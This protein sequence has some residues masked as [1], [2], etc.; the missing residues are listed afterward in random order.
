VL[1]EFDAHSRADSAS[2]EARLTSRAPR[3]NR[4]DGSAAGTFGLSQRRPDL[5]E[6]T[7]HAL[8]DQRR[9]FGCLGAS[10]ETESACLKIGG[11]GP[12]SSTC[13]P[14][15]NAVAKSS[16]PSPEFNDLAERNTTLDKDCCTLGC[17]E[18]ARDPGSTLGRSDSPGG[19]LDALGRYCRTVCLDRRTRAEFDNASDWDST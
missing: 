1:L 17:L 5:T 18:A 19:A 9:G 11:T 12:I 6:E 4:L 14:R 10:R 2:R 8:G 16:R 3:A 13:R 15:D 7:G